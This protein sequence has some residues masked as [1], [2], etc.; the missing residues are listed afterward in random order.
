MSYKNEVKKMAT[1]SFTPA[2]KNL[3]I[4]IANELISICIKCY[5]PF[6]FVNS[7]FYHT[8]LL[9]N[10]H[11]SLYL[12]LIVGRFVFPMMQNMRHPVF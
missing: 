12:K 7:F 10:S 11:N 5:Y 9:E 6:N 1:T 8:H 2:E 4:F 3:H